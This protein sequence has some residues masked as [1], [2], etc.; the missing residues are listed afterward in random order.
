MWPSS[1]RTLWEQSPHPQKEPCVCVYRSG[2]LSSPSVSCEGMLLLS[3][4]SLK[5][6]QEHF[7]ILMSGCTW[8]TISPF[9]AAF[10]N[11]AQPC[12]FSARW[13]RPGNTPKKKFSGLVS[14]VLWPWACYAN[15][16]QTELWNYPFLGT[17]EGGL[18]LFF[19]FFKACVMWELTCTDLA[20][21]CFKASLTFLPETLTVTSRPQNGGQS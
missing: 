21:K 12:Y 19:F 1:L 3:N 13:K 15:Q 8:N 4:G 14:S 18:R 17:L 5:A 20:G 11:L 6:K 2:M 16:Y 9:L 10:D 7:L